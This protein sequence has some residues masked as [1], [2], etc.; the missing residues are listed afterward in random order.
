V[1][2]L[3]LW[4]DALT[5]QKA[6]RELIVLPVTVVLF[7]GH[8]KCQPASPC[9]AQS[10]A[11]GHGF[12]IHYP[13]RP[14]NQAKL[15]SPFTDTGSERGSGFHRATQLIR[16]SQDWNSGLRSESLHCAGQ[17]VGVGLCPLSPWSPLSPQAFSQQP[18]LGPHAEFSVKPSMGR[19]RCGA[20]GGLSMHDRIGNPAQG[21]INTGETKLNK[22][23]GDRL[24]V[25]R[26][27]DGGS[28]PS[29]D[30]I[31]A[32]APMPNPGST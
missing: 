15:S 29:S 18:P 32:G 10:Q 4:N 25:S 26:Y 17:V 22:S 31:G 9:T 14:N 11:L 8:K 5:A 19:R 30:C 20:A 24:L 3:W 21:S 12:Y 27:E 23:D 6:P 16:R 1:L 13:V 28:L 7:K 2:G